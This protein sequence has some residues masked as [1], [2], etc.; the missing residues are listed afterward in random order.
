MGGCDAM[1]PEYHETLHEAMVH[2]LRGHREGLTPRDLSLA[3]ERS[4][5]WR[6]PSDGQPAAGGQISARA[7]KR[8]DL[9]WIR[10]GR[11]G[12]EPGV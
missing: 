4:S 12:L 9:F 7:N 1:P 11:I 2:A 8:P 6:K 3:V 10:D 5:T